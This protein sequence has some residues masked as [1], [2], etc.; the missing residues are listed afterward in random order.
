MTVI[1]PARTFYPAEAY[2]QDYVERTG[3]VCHVGNPWPEV[4]AAPK[5]AAPAATGAQH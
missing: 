3:R 1:E 5:D 4:L 2:H